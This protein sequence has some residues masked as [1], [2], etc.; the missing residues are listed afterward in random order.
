VHDRMMERHAA[1]DI[2]E[3]FK[4]NQ[5]IHGG[6]VRMA[7]NP[8]L[9]S[10]HETL[11]ARVKRIRFVPHDFGI[12]ATEPLHE[13]ERMMEALLARDGA[14][15]GGLLDDHMEMTWRRVSRSLGFNEP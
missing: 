12:P 14:A 9:Q 3:Y 5:Q 8:T 7:R 11:Q 15:L 4:L 13:H 10:V 2:R 6:I 1:G